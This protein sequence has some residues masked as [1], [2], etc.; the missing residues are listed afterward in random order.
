MPARGGLN[1]MS[2]AL[3]RIYPRQRAADARHRAGDEKAGVCDRRGP[4][5]D[6]SMFGDGCNIICHGSVCPVFRFRALR[7]T[8]YLA[9]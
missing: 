9:W 8:G 6:P 4:S 2:H 1:A 7:R 5:Y 3:A